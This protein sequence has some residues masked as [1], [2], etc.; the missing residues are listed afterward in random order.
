MKFNIIQILFTCF[1]WCIKITKKNSFI[2]NSYLRF[3]FLF[4]FIK[5]ATR[6]FGIIK[7]IN[8]MS[9]I[10]PFK[11]FKSIIR[12]IT[13]NMIYI[14]KII[15]IW[16][17]SFRY[18]TMKLIKFTIQFN[19]HISTTIKLWFKKLFISNGINSS[20]RINNIIVIEDMFFHNTNINKI[21]I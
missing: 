10:T 2:I 9:S 5:A 12:F 1:L 8:I 14:T 15:R 4:C 20:I 18:N 19:N 7:M 6:K 11:V 13:I 3:I 21:L 16:Y 17:K